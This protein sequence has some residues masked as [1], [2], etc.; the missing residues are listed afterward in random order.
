MLDLYLGLVYNSRMKIFPFRI[1]KALLLLA[2]IVFVEMSEVMWHF[3]FSIYKF[4]EF[5]LCLEILKI[6]GN[7]LGYDFAF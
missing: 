5:S 2:S 6:F 1:S 3:L 4:L 7:I